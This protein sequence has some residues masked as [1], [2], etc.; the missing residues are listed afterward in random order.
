[1]SPTGTLVAAFWG[2]CTFRLAPQ[3]IPRSG[4]LLAAAVAANAMLSA[5]IYGRELDASSSLVMAAIETTVII[6]LTIAVLQAFARPG[7]AVQTL[8]ALMGA[9]AVIGAIVLVLLILD[10]TLP[11]AL[12]IGVFAWNLLVVA[13][14]LRHA[15]DVHFIVGAFVAVGYA[16]FF[17]Q[18]LIVLQRLA[19]GAA[20]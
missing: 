15:L 1:M 9:G 12:R 14:V 19:V 10:P 18:L 20:A 2:V 3:D 8:T 16:I 6:G 4:A 7:R 5:A 11:R 13:H 17:S